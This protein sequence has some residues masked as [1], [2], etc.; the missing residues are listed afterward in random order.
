[1]ASIIKTLRENGYGNTP[2]EKGQEAMRQRQRRFRTTSSVGNA[3]SVTDGSTPP[4]V[5]N[6]HWISWGSSIHLCPGDCLLENPR[7]R[8]VICCWTWLTFWAMISKSTEMRLP[9]HDHQKTHPVVRVTNIKNIDRKRCRVRVQE[10]KSQWC[11]P[12]AE[13]A[14]N[15]DSTCSHSVGSYVAVRIEEVAPCGYTR[16]K[17]IES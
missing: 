6:Y 7:R 12:Q 5:G 3:P 16:S 9:Q 11:L 17:S 13:T 10:Q 1:M 8:R 15:E 4:L 2:E 14:E